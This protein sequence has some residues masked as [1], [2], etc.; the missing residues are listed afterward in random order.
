MKYFIK[1]LLVLSLTGCTILPPIYDGNEFKIM[2]EINTEVK[3]MKNK[4]VAP[5]EVLSS[6]NTLDRQTLLWTS[7]TEFLPN[8]KQLHEISTIINND[9]TE[10]KSNYNKPEKPSVTYCELKSDLLVEKMKRA[11]IAYGKLKWTS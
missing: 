5:D 10:F 1:I 6:L 11:L 9:I 8:H 7:Y 2:A 3:S 4:C